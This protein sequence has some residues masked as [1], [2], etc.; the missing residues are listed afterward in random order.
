MSCQIRGLYWAPMLGEIFRA[1]TD[2]LREADDLCCN[3]RGIVELTDLQSN[4]D[5]VA[6]QVDST[7]GDQEFKGDAGVACHEV[8]QRGGQ[9]IDRE[10][11]EY[12]H[13]QVSARRQARRRNLSLRGVDGPEN[14]TRALEIDLTLRCQGQASGRAVDEPNAQ[15]S[16]QSRDKL[17]HG[18]G[19]QPHVLSGSGKAPA[20]DYTLEYLHFVGGVGHIRERFSRVK[21]I[22]RRLCRKLK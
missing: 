5:V 18:R 8:Q 19:R 10:G 21:R 3:Q 20:F 22:S 7:V 1:G 14:V 2:N 16:L 6:D 12:V 9:M 4:V 11:R 13:P 17:R 15:P